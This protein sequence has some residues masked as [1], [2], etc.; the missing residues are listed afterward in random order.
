MQRS[1]R[2]RA[3]SERK[4]VKDKEAIERHRISQ[5]VGFEARMQRANAPTTTAGLT[6]CP[7]SGAGYISDIDRFHSDTA[8]EEY[9]I[10]QEEIQKRNRATE[11]RRNQVCRSHP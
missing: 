1:I 11:F 7:T 9:E 6:T 10:R 5:R 4:G 2:P 3:R 8:G